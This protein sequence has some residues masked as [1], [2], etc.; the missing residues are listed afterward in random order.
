MQKY[1]LLS[2]LC[3]LFFVLNS[4]ITIFAA[5]S[6]VTITLPDEV[7]HQSISDALPIR[8]QPGGGSMKGIIS[9]DSIDTLQIHDKIITIRGVIS[10]HNLVV[11]TM[12]AGQSFD[13]QLGSVQLPPIT[14]NLSVRFDPKKKALL[15]T[16]RFQQ[17]ANM[18]PND[19]TNIV[20]PL[21]KTLDGREYPIEF[22]DI[23]SFNAKIGDRTI[24][25][26]LEPIDILAM[27]KQLVLKLAPSV[28]KI[29]KK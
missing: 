22:K 26:I 7:L 24:P 14:C 12:V 10:G 9:I 20:Y 17:P 2:I 1:K 13:I 11:S 23:A 19:P 8:L 5:N 25:I 27:E 3:S 6:P 4:S 21:L 16:P 29:T 15:V 28:N 18:V